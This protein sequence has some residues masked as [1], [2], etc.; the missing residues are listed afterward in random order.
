VRHKGY[1]AKTRMI[2]LRYIRKLQIDIKKLK[3]ANEK[4]VQ[5]QG[6]RK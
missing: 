3:A 6:A 2:L 5:K 1:E 4:L